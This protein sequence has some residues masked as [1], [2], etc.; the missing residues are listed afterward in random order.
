M[1]LTAD[2]DVRIS[3]SARPVLRRYAAA[4]ARMVPH[5][6]GIEAQ[7]EEA[8]INSA[9][10]NGMK[11]LLDL[12][13]GVSLCPQANGQPVVGMERLRFAAYH[14]KSDRLILEIFVGD[15]PAET[16]YR[17]FNN[18]TGNVNAHQL[19]FLVVDLSHQPGVQRATAVLPLLNEVWEDDGYKI[20]PST[21]NRMLE[22]ANSQH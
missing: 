12:P 7:T 20:E 21:R 3:Q 5:I 9:G 4:C 1:L 19:S 6:L 15:N 18:A 10:L 8:Q 11:S 22:L 13:A 14:R 2:I 16:F 17:L